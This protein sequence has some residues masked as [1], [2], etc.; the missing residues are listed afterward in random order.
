[1]IENFNRDKRLNISDKI[2]LIGVFTCILSTQGILMNFIF[3]KMGVGFIKS[4]L[5]EIGVLILV[6]SIIYKNII[7][8]KCTKLAISD[9]FIITYVILE[10]MVL[11][12]KGIGFSGIIYTIKETW[13][14]IILIIIYKQF[15]E[16]LIRNSRLIIK[17]L[18]VLNILNLVA[19]VISLIIGPEKYM[20]ALTGRYIYPVDKELKFKVSH[21]SGILRSPA[22]IGES[23]S[24]S[25]FAAISFVIFDLY[26]CKKGKIVSLVNVFFAFTRS[27]YLFISMYIIVTFIRRF[28]IK[29][30]KSINSIT[31]SIIFIILC[32]LIGGG[33]I[34]E[35]KEFTTIISSSSSTNERLQVWESIREQ[36]IN[37]NI[38][39]SLI[40]GGLGEI[41][42][43]YNG[44]GALKVFDNTWIYLYYSIGFI[45]LGLLVI[46]LLR[47]TH[48]NYNKLAIILGLFLS[49]VF[50]NIFQSEC[51][52]ALLPIAITLCN[53][54][55]EI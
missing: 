31:F 51:I 43:A 28:N 52:I 40:G 3:A 47:E 10:V 22:L 16:T 24:F 33:I 23:A 17:I 2:F 21:I 49:M 46:F 38:M 39:E 36:N 11:L 37:E 5:F 13:L 14:A 53:K 4:F 6:I 48:N 41:G 30:Q 55:N 29:K 15:S 27:G 34:S 7:E 25:Y 45:G 44:Y 32:A 26:K 54:Y 50:I 35:S 19:T 20:T 12:I 18:L 9:L 8:R 1:M 42:N